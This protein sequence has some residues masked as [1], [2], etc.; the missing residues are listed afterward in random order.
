ML[1]FCF[2]VTS[3]AR[4]TCMCP[5]KH[6]QQRFCEAHFA[7]VATVKGSEVID[8]FMV[9]DMKVS[10][11][12][13]FKGE[14]F[15]DRASDYTK[16]FTSYGSSLCG[17]PNLVYDKKYL[18]TG[19]I[20]DGLLQMTFCNWVTEW[21]NVTP[22]QVKYLKRGTYA[23]QCNCTIA[24]AW[25]SLRKDMNYEPD[26]YH[27]SQLSGKWS[28]YKCTYNPIASA[29]F[30][31]KDCES[32]FSYCSR[33]VETGS[34]MWKSTEEYNECFNVRE[35][36]W[37]LQHPKQAAFT[38]PSQCRSLPNRRMKKKCFQAIIK[39]RRRTGNRATIDEVPIP[40]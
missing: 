1:A 18:I 2:I 33:D 29:T 39:H 37:A 31:K 30:I 14:E 6:P 23:D 9:Y 24:G 17:R 5:V 16:L 36:T 10:L 35:A 26:T 15:V 19:E 32:D 28:R 3:E 34:C 25:S 20:K 8:K 7:F 38:R 40:I 21:E 11:G 27:E 12:K 13:V 22:A 4:D